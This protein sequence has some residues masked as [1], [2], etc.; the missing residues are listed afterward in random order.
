[1]RRDETTLL[2]SLDEQKKSSLQGQRRYW[3]GWK[4]RRKMGQ[5]ACKA[6]MAPPVRQD[7]SV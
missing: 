3:R 6:T 4:S 1:M 7:S 5:P 2:I